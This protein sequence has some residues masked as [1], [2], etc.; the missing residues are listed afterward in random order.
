MG[1]SDSDR[2]LGVNRMPRSEALWPTFLWHH[3]LHL[4]K[5]E[6]LYFWRMGFAP[7]YDRDAVAAGFRSTAKRYGVRSLM[8]YEVFG[9]YDVLI[10]VWLPKACL[11]DYFHATLMNELAPA[12]LEMCDPFAVAEVA[13][14]WPFDGEGVKCS[15]EPDDDDLEV[16]LD[17]EISEIESGLENASPALLE[18]LQRQHI[19]RVYENK[20]GP[21]GVKFAVALSGDPELPEAEVEE[22]TNDV[23]GILDAAVELEQRS[24][25]VGSGFGH[26]LI[27]GRVA[28]DKFHALHRQLISQINVAAIR[29]KYE[30]HTMTSVSGQRGFHIANEGLA[31]PSESI[32]ID[33]RPLVVRGLSHSPEHF[34]RLKEGEIFAERFEIKEYLGGGGYAHVYRVGDLCEMVD[35]AIKIFPSDDPESALRELA[36]L[37]RIEHPNVVKLFWY[38]KAPGC[39]FLVN[40]FIEGYSLDALGLVDA[41]EA[42][43]IAAQ[44]LDALQ[45]LHPKDERI[46]EL[47]D[48]GRDETGMTIGELA[49][50]QRLQDHALIHRDIKPANIMLRNDGVVKIVDFNIA[51]PADGPRETTSHTPG[52]EPP[53]LESSSPRWEPDVDL[54]ACGVVLFELICGEMPYPTKPGESLVLKD[55][56][57][58]VQGLRPSIGQLLRRACAAERADRFTSAR[59]M[60]IAVDREIRMGEDRRQEVGREF[61]GLRIGPKNSAEERTGLV[62]MDN[63]SVSRHK[64]DG[65]IS[66]DR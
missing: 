14:H 40:E 55:P 42:L 11:P 34:A 9:A 45:Y 60:A 25:Y 41:H 29:E 64:E 62:D 28:G 49:E 10:R 56:C 13:R 51:S 17:S 35:R 52:Y 15:D 2:S 22:L 20:P 47:R 6:S 48:K 43:K 31:R 65:E 57:E 16:L 38:E 32:E 39:C 21:P 63:G 23:I 36:A 59:D 5:G 1:D 33:M 26:L 53:D 61:R 30:V 50:F 27:I 46:A 44:I 4:Q 12:G 24:L 8:S 66:L 37:R 7:T 3:K 54:F 19:V 18:R 58:M